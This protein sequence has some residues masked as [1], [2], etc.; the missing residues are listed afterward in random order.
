MHSLDKLP[1]YENIPNRAIYRMTQAKPCFDA[2]KNEEHGICFKPNAKL[3]LVIEWTT[4]GANIKIES[5]HTI[6]I[7][8]CDCYT[9]DGVYNPVRLW[10]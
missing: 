5:F 2:P 1:H 8:V 7:N 4:K 3:V 10:L 9:R 6:S